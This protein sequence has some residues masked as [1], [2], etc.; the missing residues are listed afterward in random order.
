MDG[1][2]HEQTTS[3]DAVL[4]LVEEGG[5]HAKSYRLVQIAV[6]EDD[7]R[8]FAA[9]FKRYLVVIVQLYMNS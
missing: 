6:F 7:Q 1:V 4:A 8:R 5:R 3:G 9:Q 2:L